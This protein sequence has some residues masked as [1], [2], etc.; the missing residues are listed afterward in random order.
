MSDSLVEIKGNFER[1]EGEIRTDSA[2]YI[3]QAGQDRIVVM[4]DTGKPVS[5]QT[6]LP[7]SNRSLL[8]GPRFMR[9]RGPPRRS[10]PSKA[11][12]RTP[13]HCYAHTGRGRQERAPERS[14][15]NTRPLL[16]RIALP[17]G[18]IVGAYLLLRML[19]KRLPEIK[20]LWKRIFK[21]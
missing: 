5:S 19:C 17:A 9:N 2:G 18:L 4:F 6:G 3:R 1:R 12:G 8:P 11:D 21:G 14:E 10:T 13:P 15:D 20:A 16:R 7:P